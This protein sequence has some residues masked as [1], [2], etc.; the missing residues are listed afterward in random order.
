[1]E[2][3]K[4]SMRQARRFLLRRHG[5]LGGY[6]Y[7]GREGALDF[8]R[9]AGCIQFDPV[10]VCGKNAELTL[11]SRVKGFSK[12][13]LS[14]L[15]YEERRLVDYPDKN[16]AI[17]PV[18]DW[19]YFERY[20]R[21][22]RECGA[23]FDG[24]ERVTE[25]AEK[26]IRENGPVSS[27]ELPIEG[28]ISWHSAIHW[29]GNWHGDHPADRAALEQL[30]SEGRLVIHHKQGARKYYDL[31]ERHVPRH[32]LGAPDPL[33]DD[34]DNI[35]WRVKRRTGAVGLMWD[36]PSDAWLHIWGLDAEKRSAAFACLAA[37]GEILPAQIEGVRGGVWFR[38]E[39]L[40]LV[41]EALS[42]KRFAPRCEAIAPLDP[43]MWDRKLI[44]RIFGFEYSWE[45]YTPAE[46]RRYGYYVLP[47]VYGENFAGRIE[48]IPEKG[49]LIL[50]HFWPE[51]GFR[52]TEAF[53]RALEDCVSRL[54]AFN[55]CAGYSLE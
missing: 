15:L 11:Q 51:D 53:Q 19:P 17:I 26:Y 8:V 16:Q 39:D 40:P 31:A 23:Q 42:A 3:V 24:L 5:L 49:V 27:A 1:M 55:G 36:R 9:S 38:K 47:V 48:A 2:A 44:K 43:L 14:A 33:P 50:K 7:R 37:R 6:R 35:C 45:I 46:K 30:Y 22:A 10:D 28:R 20:R 4:L 25:Q 12:G 32:I 54:A 21:A 41:E 34:M 52:Q 13:M 29:S 18:E